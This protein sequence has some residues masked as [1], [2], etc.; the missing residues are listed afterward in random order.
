[1]ANIYYVEYD[2]THPASFVFDMPGGHD[3]WLLVLTQTPAQFWVDGHMTEYPANS[4][5][6]Y[7]PH[8][9]ILYRACSDRYVNDWVRFDSAEPYIIDTAIPLGTPFPLSDP[10]YCHKLFQLLVAENTLSNSHKELTIDYLLKVLFIKLREAS[11]H[12]KNFSQ[13]QS[14]LE[15]RRNI[16]NNPGH[17]W[18]VPAM[19]ESL[20]LSPG[21]LQTLYKETFGVS[22]MKDVINCRIRFAKDQLSHSPHTI[23]DI[24]ILCG[25]N[26]V[27]HFV[28]QFHQI[29][30]CT[31]SAFRNSVKS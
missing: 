30:G 16:H 23:A 26:N 9:K 28:R 21:Y 2:A 14:I 20:H 22:C 29:T 13:I 31:P 12:T 6:L 4:A 7:P 24:S 15:L 1:M 17:S 18:S 11:E 25:Y 27:E 5:V 10:E 8:H 3:C 19:A